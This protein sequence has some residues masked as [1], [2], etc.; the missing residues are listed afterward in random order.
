MPAPPDGEYLLVAIPDA[1]ASDW[2]NPAMLQ[3]L[4]E[5][6]EAIQVRDGQPL[7]RTLPLRRLR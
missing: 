3:R 1:Q 6:A 7:T 4:A 2:A 5:I